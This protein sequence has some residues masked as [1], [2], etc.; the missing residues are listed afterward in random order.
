MQRLLF[1]LLLLICSPFPFSGQETSVRYRVSF[2]HVSFKTARYERIERIAVFMECGRFVALNVIPDDWSATIVSPVSE[3]TTLRMEAGHG[4]SELSRSEELND[5]VTVLAFP[6]CFKIR[7]SIT[8]G[9]Y[10]GNDLHERKISVKQSEL[11]L[12]AEP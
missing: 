11:I 3:R 6:S 8:A 9:Y 1:S 5:F 12:K 2:P 7:A 4:S 10:Q